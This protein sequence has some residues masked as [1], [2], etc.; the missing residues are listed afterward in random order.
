MDGYPIDHI[1]ERPTKLD[2]K[3]LLKEMGEFCDF[4][5]NL[6]KTHIWCEKAKD[7][8]ERTNQND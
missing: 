1:P 7:F 5:A 3:Q 4:M 6:E 8:I 2:Q